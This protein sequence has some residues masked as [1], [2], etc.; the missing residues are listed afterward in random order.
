MIS[1]PKTFQRWIGL[2]LVLAL[3]LL[4][5][6]GCSLL[7]PEPRVP[8]PSET[9][10]E[11][12][13]AG[14]TAILLPGRWNRMEAFREQGFGA[15]VDEAGLDLGLVAADAHIGYYREESVAIRLAAD[16]VGPLL[17]RRIPKGGTDTRHTS[18]GISLCGVRS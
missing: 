1:I 2:T 11:A 3:A 15:A 13:P 17:A 7:V 12:G 9:L 10:R 18:S 8:I 5:G 14:C 4:L 6:G 16:V